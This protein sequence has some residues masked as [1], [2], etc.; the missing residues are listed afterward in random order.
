[1]CREL[2]LVLW[3]KLELLQVDEKGTDGNVGIV[4]G[5]VCVGC[6]QLLLVLWGKL[7]LLVSGHQ[8]R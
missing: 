4:A 7:D 6:W 3:E 2:L 8:C 5:K 1:M